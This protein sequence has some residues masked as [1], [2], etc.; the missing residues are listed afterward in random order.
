MSDTLARICADKRAHVARR[1]ADR[2]LAALETEARER[3]GAPTAAV[4]GFY[5]RPR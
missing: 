1:K 4:N 5:L 3:L 2:P